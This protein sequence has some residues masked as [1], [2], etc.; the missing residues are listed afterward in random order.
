[1]AYPVFAVLVYR[2]GY[3]LRLHIS[4]RRAFRCWLEYR[5]KLGLWDVMTPVRYGW[6]EFP[7][8][9]ERH[10]DLFSAISALRR[11]NAVT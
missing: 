7:K 10:T 3:P 6:Q 11:L 8:P 5:P 1:M 2:Q 4:P 9:A